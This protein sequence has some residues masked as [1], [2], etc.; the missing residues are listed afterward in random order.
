M[1][2]IK[3]LLCFVFIF[4]CKP[5]FGEGLVDPGRAALYLKVTKAANT[6]IR[7]QNDAIIA[8]SSGHATNA[9]I[10][11]K[12]NKLLREYDEY[13]KNV[14]KVLV[15]AA[16]IYGLYYECDRC[17]GHL[18][19]TRHVLSNNP[20]NV[21]AVALT[22]LR[23]DI[24]K[25]VIDIGM[26]IVTDLSSLMPKKKTKNGKVIFNYADLGDR[27]MAVSKL[28]KDVIKFN[29]RIMRLNMILKSTTF[30]DA[31]YAYIDR[32]DNYRTRSINEITTE[33]LNVWA[34]KARG[35]RIVW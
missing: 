18:N 17:V 23:R 31:W 28:R 11:N 29:R 21:V 9:L 2:G 1:K 33:C 14:R 20:K 15:L 5:T 32:H 35:G 24:F 3:I 8:N 30:M 26:E 12:E 16:N 22:P 10:L 7:L 6:T 25:E 4:V 19:E 27:I 34:D 13:L